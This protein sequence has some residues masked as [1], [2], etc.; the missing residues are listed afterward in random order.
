MDNSLE[1]E[2]VMP[3]DARQLTRP[4]LQ[5]QWLSLTKA[6]EQ[7]LADIAVFLEREHPD[8]VAEIANEIGADYTAHYIACAIQYSL[9]MQTGDAWKED[10]RR[11]ILSA[12]FGSYL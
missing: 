11:R 3:N 8:L 9:F 4:Q 5:Q 12:A 6:N 1:Q 2:G 7:F 10:V